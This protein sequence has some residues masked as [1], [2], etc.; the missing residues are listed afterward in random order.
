MMPPL[1]EVNRTA[2]EGW[3]KALSKNPRSHS[4]V[5][6]AIVGARSREQVDGWIAAADVE[7]SRHDMAEIAQAIRHAGA[8]SGPERPE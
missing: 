6:A 2:P 5:T 8:G 3:V 7:L 1:Y 4:A